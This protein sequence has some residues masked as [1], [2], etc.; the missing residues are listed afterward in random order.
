[1]LAQGLAK[2]LVGHGTDIAFGVPGGGPNLDVV[3]A[4]ADN[5]IRFIL[6]HGETAACIMASTYGYVSGRVSATVVTRGPGAASA[7]NGAAQATLD[8]HPLVLIT[9]TVPAETAD[10]V[11]HQRLDQRALFAPL[12]KASATLDRSLPA[13]Q[14]DALIS[15]A[16]QSPA[17]AIHL[18]YDTST[19]SV[20]TDPPSFSNPAPHPDP[21]TEPDPAPEGASQAL[22]HARA[23][24]SAADRPVVIAGIGATTGPDTGNDIGAALL[25]FGAPVLT[26]YQAIGVVPTEHR[27]AA[28]LFTNGASERPLLDQADLIVTVGLD[29]V[30]PI[31]A[32]WT[33]QAPVVSL[34]NVATPDPYLPFAV[35]AV[36]DVATMLQR[37]NEQRPDSDHRW[38]ADAGAQHRIAVREDLA[39]GPTASAPDAITPIELVETT[40]ANTPDDA[41]TTV[42]AGAHFLAIMPLWSVSQPKRLLISNGLATMGYALPAAVGAALARPGQPVLCMVGDGGLGM[43]LAELETVARLDLPITVLVFNDSALSLI[44]IKQGNNHGGSEVVSYRGSDFAAVAKGLGLRAVTV[45][46]TDELAAE[47][48]N[49]WDRPRLIDVAVNP[50]SY[51]HLITVTRG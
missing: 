7:A 45:T 30:E 15:L 31:P 36:G 6:A 11:P 24:I 21:A 8:R 47:L 44:Q 17:G 26:T 14:L 32:P 37:L 13:K 25:Q 23:M 33:Y 18:D 51:R 49:G 5:D 12:C 35:E 29:P 27:L 34:S 50:D 43:T 20:P 16:A 4:M 1:M 48:A 41:T 9:D 22:D 3:G 42:D 39:A 40:L 19:V 10:R 46:D 2:A 38:S 28:G